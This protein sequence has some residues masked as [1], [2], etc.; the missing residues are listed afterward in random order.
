MNEETNTVE[1]TEPEQPQK[2]TIEI[3][4]VEEEVSIDDLKNALIENRQFKKNAEW[5]TQNWQGEHDVIH[6]NDILKNIHVAYKTGKISEKKEKFLKAVM[7]ERFDNLPTV[8]MF[9]DY[10]IENKVDDNT[11]KAAYKNYLKDEVKET[12]PEFEDEE[13]RITYK[14]KKELE[15]EI[16][17]MRTDFKEALE[18]LKEIKGSMTNKQVKEETEAYTSRIMGYLNTAIKES[19][20]ELPEVEW[21]ERIAKV[22][23]EIYEDQGVRV[24]PKIASHLVSEAAKGLKIKEKEKPQGKVPGHIELNSERSAV[25]VKNKPRKMSSDE[26]HKVVNG[27]N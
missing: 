16:E 6:K 14:A 4:N 9:L 17:K 27:I 8:Q 15:P 1:S 21:E 10:A 13:Q 22:Y 25:E 11:L 12:E 7:D 24:T 18:E 20:I 2:I 26:W 3:G 5:F 23:K 19:G